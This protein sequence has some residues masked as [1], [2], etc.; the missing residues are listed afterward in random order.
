MYSS[1]APYQNEPHGLVC[2]APKSH[3]VFEKAPTIR[4]RFQYL[5]NS[6][7]KE[8]S[9]SWAY[10]GT[11]KYLETSDNISSMDAFKF[12]NHDDG[13]ISIE[14]TNGVHSRLVVKPV[15]TYQYAWFGSD[16]YLDANVYDRFKLIDNN[17]GTVSIECPGSTPSYLAIGDVTTY[18]CLFFGTDEYLNT[19]E[20]NREFRL[21]F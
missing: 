3:K 17:N 7:V 5:F 14:S 20:C 1:F 10:I 11:Q 13:T 12:I 21:K 4:V 15:N 16:A 18:G 8:N 6:P 9:Y 19:I 2:L